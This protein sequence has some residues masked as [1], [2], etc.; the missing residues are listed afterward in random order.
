MV[1]Y[2]HLLKNFPQFV[3]IHTVKGFSIVNE[4]DV[5]LEFSFVFSI[6]QWTLAIWSLVPPPFLNP[7]WTFVSSRFTYCWSLAW[8]ILSITLLVCE[9]LDQVKG[10]GRGLSEYD[11]HV[12]TCQDSRMIQNYQ[13]SLQRDLQTP[14]SQRAWGENTW[15]SR[16]KLCWPLA[17]FLQVPALSGPV[18]SLQTHPSTLIGITQKHGTL[19]LVFYYFLFCFKAI[20]LIFTY[21]KYLHGSFFIYYFIKLALKGTCRSRKCTTHFWISLAVPF[22]LP[23]PHFHSWGFSLKCLQPEHHMTS[24]P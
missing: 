16:E 7:A 24:D 20:C 6:I 3:V 21:K 5:Y 8:R 18:S 14:E 11:V 22:F 2:S 4:A 19:D 12:N 13:V 9:I 1:W 10:W 17:T 23:P 15:E